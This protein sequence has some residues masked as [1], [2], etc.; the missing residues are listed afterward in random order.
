MKRKKQM[1]LTN[2][3]TTQYRHDTSNAP[4]EGL[5]KLMLPYVV[6][7]FHD[8]TITR[9]GDAFTDYSVYGSVVT[10]GIT[11]DDGDTFVI[12]RSTDLD[13]MSVFYAGAPLR[14]EDL[15]KNFELI[16]SKLEEL[17]A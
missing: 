3:F 16:K 2:T 17:D 14:A 13:Q 12:T 10:L 8:L 4:W 6:E 7:K 9:N 15:N 11:P 1:P 5:N